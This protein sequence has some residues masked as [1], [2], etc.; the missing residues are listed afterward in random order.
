LSFC[1]LLSS[2][3]VLS[4]VLFILFSILITV[5]ILIILG[6][7][8]ENKNCIFVISVVLGSYVSVVFWTCIVFL[9][10]VLCGNVQFTAVTM[11]DFLLE[12][13]RI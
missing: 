13:T 11:L 5:R 9:L 8:F 12:L 7:V 1:A 4:Q 10:D 2:F 6:N 3:Q